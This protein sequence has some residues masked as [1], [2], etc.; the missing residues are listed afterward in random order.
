[1][2]KSK[3]IQKQCNIA[4]KLSDNEAR[5]SYLRNI[6]NEI[7]KSVRQ[8]YCKPFS[9]QQRPK[10]REWVTSS[11]IRL[12]SGFDFHHH[13]KDEIVDF[14]IENRGNYNLL[15]DD[16]ND[17]YL[18][19]FPAP[20][21]SGKAYMVSVNGN[22]RRLVFSCIGLPIVSAEVQKTVGNKWRFFWRGQNLNAKKLL[23]WLKYKGIVERIEQYPDDMFTLVISDASN[24]SG[25]IIPDPN[26]HDLKKMICDMQDRA[27]ILKNAFSGLDD[28]V[29]SLLKS[30]I[31]LYLSIQY[32]YYCRNIPFIDN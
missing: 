11:D 19:E 6:E 5:Q 28:K 25:W 12:V 26:L 7:A 24:I 20:S 27:N 31:L 21:A 4:S 1:M 8:P 29:S 9:E 22:H 3:I 15:I 14:A 10:I 23:K 18:D 2:N 30:P 13:K 32:T 17:L 16:M